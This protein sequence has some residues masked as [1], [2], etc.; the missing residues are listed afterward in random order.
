MLRVCDA[1]VTPDKC[2]EEGLGA[3]HAQPTV[4]RR[5][6][7]IDWNAAFLPKRI[8]RDVLVTD[9]ARD[10][11]RVFNGSSTPSISNADRPVNTRPLACAKQ[12]VVDCAYDKFFGC[13]SHF[14]A[15]L[16]TLTDTP[17]RTTV[18]D[19]PGA[20]GTLSVSCVNR[21]VPDEG[22]TVTVYFVS[23][24]TF[25]TSATPCH[26]RTRIRNGCPRFLARRTTL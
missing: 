9:D 22:W 21:T 7:R 23:M 26:D 8:C 24:V 10:A 25:P 11:R 18:N 20:T 17:P 5:S 14:V 15:L 3:L 19:F 12:C 1:R 16:E 6:A 13:S 2:C 4:G